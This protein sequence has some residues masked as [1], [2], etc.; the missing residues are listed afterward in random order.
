M[1]YP[2]DIPYTNICILF[3]C[4]Y[5]HITGF[6][7]HIVCRY[8]ILSPSRYHRIF[9]F[10][11]ISLYNYIIIW[12]YHYITMSLFGPQCVGESS[13]CCCKTSFSARW[14]PA[15]SQFVA[16]GRPMCQGENCLKNMGFTWSF[17]LCRPILQVDCNPRCKWIKPLLLPLTTRDITYLGF[18]GSATY[19]WFL[20]SCHVWF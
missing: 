5:R 18:V 12:L 4:G 19:I 10:M 11:I 3:G 14:S 7:Y 1:C 16:P 6:I 13:I 17:I 2:K 9:F 20:P 15:V 8:L